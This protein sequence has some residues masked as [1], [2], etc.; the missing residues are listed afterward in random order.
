M[1]YIFK[2]RYDISYVPILFNY[3]QFW[4]D[5]DQVITNS[6]A[7]ADPSTLMFFLLTLIPADAF[8]CELVGYI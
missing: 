6:Q 4:D 7:L 1:S 2:E 5:L 8:S 3:L